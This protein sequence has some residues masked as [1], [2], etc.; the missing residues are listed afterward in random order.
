VWLGAAVHPASTKPWVQRCET[1]IQRIGCVLHPASSLSLN[2]RRTSKKMGQCFACHSRQATKS[3]GKAKRSS[4]V[5]AGPNNVFG[6]QSGRTMVQC[7]LR[8]QTLQLEPGF[9]VE[10][11]L[12]TADARYSGVAWLAFEVPVGVLLDSLQYHS[13]ISTYS[14]MNGLGWRAEEEGRG[15]RDTHPST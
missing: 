10:N 7:S 9:F 11:R 14:C 8:L 4:N 15:D 1:W 3:S 13:A 6:G 12:R 2:R 5:S